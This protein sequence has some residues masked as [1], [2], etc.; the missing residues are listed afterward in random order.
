MR[1]VLVIGSSGA[2]KSVLA[3]RLAERTGLPLVH[4]DAI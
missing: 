2:G 4:L 3:A 1:K